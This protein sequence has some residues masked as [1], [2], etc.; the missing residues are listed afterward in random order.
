MKTM[1]ALPAKNSET[2]CNSDYNN[3][4][5]NTLEEENCVKMKRKNQIST[6]C[7]CQMATDPEVLS[8]NQCDFYHQNCH[9]LDFNSSFSE[10]NFV[11]TCSDG[12]GD[13]NVNCSNLETDDLI[14]YETYLENIDPENLC[15][16]ENCLTTFKKN[17]E[18]VLA[19]YGIE[20]GDEQTAADHNFENN[21]YSDQVENCY[22]FADNDINND[23]EEEEP[24]LVNESSNVFVT[25]NLNSTFD[26]GDN[27][28][29]NNNHNIKS[30][31]IKNVIL[32]L[33]PKPY[34]P[35]P[36]SV[37]SQSMPFIAQRKQEKP[38]EGLK[39]VTISLNC[40]VESCP[41]IFLDKPQL[42]FHM[43][44]AHDMHPFKCW[45]GCVEKYFPC[46]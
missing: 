8:V 38:L 25:D 33:P 30:R 40:K 9:N 1:S 39:I 11:S 45:A 4:R 27:M 10:D 6:E 21:Q 46:R 7:A 36:V 26:T 16:C 13:N 15:D 32:D 37:F 28:N 18:R 2:D 24:I 43:L 20:V 17:P 34:E 41:L 35:L 44:Y 31:L 19:C 23:N 14:K 42:D 22:R 3:K 29:S 5:N 12:N